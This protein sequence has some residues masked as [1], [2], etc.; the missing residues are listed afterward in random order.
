MEPWFT[1]VVQDRR[2]AWLR[3]DLAAGHVP[4]TGACRLPCGVP[5]WLAAVRLRRPV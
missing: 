5:P 3:P 2:T 1:G 4:T